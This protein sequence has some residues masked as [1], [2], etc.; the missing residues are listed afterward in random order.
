MNLTK[1]KDEIRSLKENRI[2]KC[3]CNICYNKDNKLEG[4]RQTVMA[5]DKFVS[6]YT[7][8]AYKSKRQY[9]LWKQIKE[10]LNTKNTE[11]LKEQDGT[12]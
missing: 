2:G 5:V 11:K 7:N 6:A 9:Q 1:L 4:I 10:S 3:D 8:S 12:T